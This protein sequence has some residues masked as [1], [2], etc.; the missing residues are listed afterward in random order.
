ME[1]TDLLHLNI[2]PSGE[3]TCSNKEY[4]KIKVKK[5]AGLY[6]PRQS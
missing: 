4:L 2:I 1:V 6:Q 3:K 5:G